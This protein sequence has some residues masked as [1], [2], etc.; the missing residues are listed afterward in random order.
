MNTDWPRVRRLFSQWPGAYSAFIVFVACWW[1][2]WNAVAPVAAVAIFWAGVILICRKR[3]DPGYT[4]T[5]R[6]W[7]R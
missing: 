7:H 6:E 3:G 5:M 2:S 1:P 4:V